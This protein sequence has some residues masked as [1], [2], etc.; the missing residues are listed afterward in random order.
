MPPR[1]ERLLFWHTAGKDLW[2]MSLRWHQLQCYAYWDMWRFILLFK[3]QFHRLE[4]CY[5]WWEGFREYAV[6][7]ASCVRV[8]FASSMKMS[9]GR[10]ST[11]LSSHD[12][13]GS[14]NFGRTNGRQSW[15]R[16]LRW[17]QVPLIYTPKKKKKLRGL[18]SAS[19]RCVGLTTLPP[20]MSRLSRQCG[21]LN[22]LQPYRPPR[23]V[24]R[25]ALL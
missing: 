25:I 10:S 18:Q 4:S 21:I 6:E 16:S 5:S 2:S 9:R 1:T 13:L 15:S 8:H 14:C 3:Y 12:S 11:R 17:T 24:K 7:M 23:P 22:I 20:S 19:G